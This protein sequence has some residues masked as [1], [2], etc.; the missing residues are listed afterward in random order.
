MQARLRNRPATVWLD[1]LADLDGRAAA[2]ADHCAEERIARGLAG[3]FADGEVA[4]RELLLAELGKFSG[5]I[6]VALCNLGDLACIV[7]FG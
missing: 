6:R 2:G 7:L 5:Q 4:V 1:F 3:A